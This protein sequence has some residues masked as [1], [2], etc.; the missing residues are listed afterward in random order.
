MMRRNGGYEFLILHKNDNLTRGT[1]LNSDLQ[2]A[3]QKA[4][5]CGCEKAEILEKLGEIRKMVENGGFHQGGEANMNLTAYQETLIEPVAAGGRECNTFMDS[6]YANDLKNL[7]IATLDSDA[8]ELLEH[9][10]NI[11]EEDTDW[12]KMPSPVKTGGEWGSR[13]N[14]KTPEKL[15]VA[16]KGTPK[17]GGTNKFDSPCREKAT[18]VATE[19][20]MQNRRAT[21]PRQAKKLTDK[22]K[23]KEIKKRDYLN[24]MKKMDVKNKKVS[25]V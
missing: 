16:N 18:Q 2:D 10:G 25:D 8:D 22:S 17:K 1:F 14:L 3:I 4:V 12:A 24:L 21:P 11:D 23:E 9:L 7:A 15:S 5:N 6:R 13:G 20:T 19:T